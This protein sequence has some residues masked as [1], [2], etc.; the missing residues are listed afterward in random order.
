MRKIFAFE[1]ATLDGYYAGPNQEFD[2]PNVD[3]E[4]NEFS[5][6]QLN[7]V[8]ML[9]FGRHTYE[10]MA[11]YWPTPA[12]QQGDPVVSGIMN[13]IQKAVVTRTLDRADWNNTLL[14]KGDDA[15]REIARIKERSGKDIA[16]FGSFDLTVHLME[17]GLVDE[18]RIMINPIIL[19]AGLS[20]F[21]TATERIPVKLRKVRRFDSGNV[22]LHYQPAA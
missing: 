10:A 17:A 16:V 21:R 13:S 5:V 9:L 20:L 3:E 15:I 4:F 2:W 18:L 22:L 7:E 14:I 19:G 12:A 1:V 6:A 11:S 8:D